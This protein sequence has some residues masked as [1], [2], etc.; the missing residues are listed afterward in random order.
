MKPLVF[1]RI[2][3]FS[4]H[5]AYFSILTYNRIIARKNEDEFLNHDIAAD[6]SAIIYSAVNFVS[7]SFLFE[8]LKNFCLSQKLKSYFELRNLKWFSLNNCR[9]NTKLLRRINSGLA[10]M[11]IFDMNATGA[12][13]FSV[14]ARTASMQED[15]GEKERSSLIPWR[16]QPS[17]IPR[18]AGLPVI[19]ESLVTLEFVGEYSVVLFF[20][21]SPLPLSFSVFYPIEIHIPLPWRVEKRDGDAF[22]MK[23][24]S[25]KANTYREINSIWSLNDQEYLIYLIILILLFLGF[26]SLKK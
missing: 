20:S 5:F 10:D 23:Y 18:A 16:P 3:E 4:G 9:E 2:N 22:H 21:L 15:E 19:C 12:V 26:L 11:N 8:R 1:S 25:L 14:T 13:G 7:H 24:F 17:C 6:W